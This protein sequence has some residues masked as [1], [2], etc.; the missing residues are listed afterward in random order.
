MTNGNVIK[1]V[2]HNNDKRR[3]KVY[4]DRKPKT[5]VERDKRVC[6][7]VNSSGQVIR[8]DEGETLDLIMELS[9][10]LK[11]KASRPGRF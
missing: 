2:Y 1:N 3:F 6:L 9:K 10:A 11:R 8:L 7:V 5:S 4:Y